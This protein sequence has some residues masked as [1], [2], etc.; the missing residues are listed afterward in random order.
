MA[1]NRK[2][3]FVSPLH[4]IA[5]LR[6]EKERWIYRV[7][8][9]GSIHE[10]G[11]P[12]KQRKEISN[13]KNNLEN[14]ERA[15]TKEEAIRK[16]KKLMA[17]AADS[18]AS[19]QEIQLAVYRANKLRI[20]YKIQ[21][22]DLYRTSLHDRKD[23][24]ITELKQNGCGYIHWVLKSLA[25]YYQ[26]ETGFKGRI[27]SNNVRFFIIGLQEDVD[28]CL[29]VAQGLIYYLNSMLSDLKE[30]YIGTKDFRIFKRDYLRGFSKGLSDQ[31]QK[32]MDGVDPKYALAVIGVP[33]VVKTWA[34]DTL[35]YKKSKFVQDEDV[36]AWYL[37]QKHGI[38]YDITRLDLIEGKQVEE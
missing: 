32:S 20:Q 8:R 4:I 18:S 38:E 27:N 17:V 33:E 11:G 12:V 24:I 21:E 25:Q 15:M 3:V 37:G 31:L 29:P 28:M 2:E 6:G 5:M 1:K 19:D 35:Q 26:C 22:N 13:E 10:V 36:S 23:V 7:G 14:G 30:C 16:I 34:S 9:R